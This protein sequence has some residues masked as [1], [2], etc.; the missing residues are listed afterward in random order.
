MNLLHLVL[1]QWRQRPARTLLSILSVA[2][3]IA[4]ALGT[5]LA[6][7]S[8]RKGVVALQNEI[9]GA[10]TLEIVSVAGGR[11][12]PADVPPLTDVPG[13]THVF[14]VVSR[15][16]M[17]R[18]HGK[19]FRGVLLGL[20]V[21][22]KAAWSA[23]PL[24]DGRICEG[25][26]EAILAA[27]TAE[28]L[29]AVPGDRLIV[30]ARGRGPCS[31][32]IVG[33][34]CAARRWVDSPPARNSG[35]AEMSTVEKLF[36]LDGKVDRLRL[37]LFVDKDVPRLDVLTAVSARLPDTLV[38]QAPAGQIEQNRQHATSAG[39]CSAICRRAVDCN[40]RVSHSQH[41]TDEFQRAPP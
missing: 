18:V 40:G 5:A 29:G 14:P 24:T 16:T 23:L 10:P 11:F 37:R 34:A 35:D 32:T 2:I 28:S 9:G 25:P 33:L 36:G 31:A 3:A 27:E 6:Q 7:S 22:Q 4:A 26:D 12:A 30:I 41:A 19:R 38:V 39:A 20:P 8:V 21:E 1:R 13:V 17:G 15:P